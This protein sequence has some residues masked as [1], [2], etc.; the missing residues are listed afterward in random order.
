MAW[1][2]LALSSCWASTL[3]TCGEEKVV[4]RVGGTGL[5]PGNQRSPTRRQK[6]AA[7]SRAALAQRGADAGPEEAIGSQ[8]GRP[9]PPAPEGPSWAPREQTG[10]SDNLQKPDEKQAWNLKGIDPS[11]TRGGGGVSTPDSFYRG[12]RHTEDRVTTA[13]AQR[14]LL[15]KMIA[16]Q[17]RLPWKQGRP[18]SGGCGSHLGPSRRGY[19]RRGRCV[20]AGGGT[21]DPLSPNL[22]T[23]Q[24]DLEMPQGGCQSRPSPRGRVPSAGSHRTTRRGY[25]GGYTGGCLHTFSQQCPGAPRDQPAFVGETGGPPSPPGRNYWPRTQESSFSGFFPETPGRAA[26]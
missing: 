12:S 15:R 1:E 25:Y 11:V 19:G 3:R 9:S 20:S 4:P 7:S 2:T 22:S 6:A 10:S 8:R 18:L 21:R 24:P 13:A 5:L 26:P 16:K 14:R 17:H 23:G